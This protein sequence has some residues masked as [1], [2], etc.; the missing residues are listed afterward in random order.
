MLSTPSVPTIPTPSTASSDPAAPAASSSPNL[1]SRRNYSYYVLLSISFLLILASALVILSRGYSSRS[2][3]HFCRQLLQ[4]ELTANTL[5]MHYTTACPEDY[6]IRSYTARLPLYT[7][8][9]AETGRQELTQTIQT[10]EDI[11]PAGLSKSDVMT[12]Q[13]LLSGLRQQLQG[14]DYYYYSNPLSPSSGMQS[15]LP[16]LLAEYSFRTLRDI[17]DYLEL[18]DQTDDYFQSLTDFLKEQSARGL[19]MPD[20]A[21][22]EV[23]LQCD[24]IM[25]QEEISTGRHFLH[26]SFT[27]RLDAMV[28]KGAIT[29][30]QKEDY[31]ARNHRLLSTVVLPA[32]QKLGDELL[33]LKG[34][35]QNSQ[36]LAHTP[37]G[38]DYYLWLLQES[39]GSG[40]SI[41][42]I[43]QMLLRDFQN[44]QTGLS[45]LLRTLPEQDTLPAEPDF[46]TTEPEEMLKSL[47]KKMVSDFPSLPATEDTP[48]PHCVVKQ[49]S[50]SL[51]PYTSPAFYLTPPLDDIS[52]HV[53]YLNPEHNSSPIELYTTLAHE[54]YPGHLYQSV[55]N[56]LYAEH[57][58]TDPIRSLLSYP[59]YTE[60]WAMYV[61]LRSYQYAADLMKER[62]PET[63]TLYQIYRLQRQLQLCLYSLL[64]IA[65]HYDGASPEEAGRILSSIGITDPEHQRS[66]YA[67]IVG[68]PCNY[69]KYYLGYLEILS[70]RQQAEQLW[71]N[72]YSDY[73]FHSFLLEYGPAD[74]PTLGTWLKEYAGQDRTGQT[75]LIQPSRPWIGLYR[76]GL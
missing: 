71:G 65:I 3:R 32:Y 29:A 61:E 21:V 70:L 36:G 50:P 26:T 68:E 43:K 16:I 46:Y 33:L 40:R 18:L 14:L 59:G 24:E 55:Y 4:S 74:F 41:D 52:E 11:Q 2:F 6:G 73:R 62:V 48:L 1:Q 20:Y 12:R 8:E 10:L 7:P 64:D 76:H 47:Q 27:Q 53:I 25:D 56:R 69:L 72:R 66:V 5:H 67:Y 9:Q 51:S 44:N 30:E 75:L 35:A 49:I 38:R 22:E 17:E 23:I 13:L 58:D 34:T 57:T 31:L 37:E 39:T 15:Q 60:G 45:A 54:G 42:E 19:F 28:E 63:E